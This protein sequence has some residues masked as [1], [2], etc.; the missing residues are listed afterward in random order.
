M[1]LPHLSVAAFVIASCCTVAAPAHA[2][3]NLSPRACQ[4]Y[5]VWSG[6]LVWASQLGADK[7]KA[8]ADLVARN[9]KTPANIYALMLNDL[10]ALWS[11]SAG[12]EDIMV[13]VYKDCIAR[14]GLYQT[15]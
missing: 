6:N 8:R 3:I 5:A 2:Q 15:G 7:E 12:W 11:T 10:D 9:A 1:R 4:S 14:K 13:L